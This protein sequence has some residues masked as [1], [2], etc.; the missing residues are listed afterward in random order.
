MKKRK[1][2]TVV[3]I[4]RIVMEAPPK[5]TI[6]IQGERSQE[7]RTGIKK[8]A[9]LAAANNRNTINKENQMKNDDTT[10]RNTREKIEAMSRANEPS[11][12]T[13]S[14]RHCGA[15]CLTNAVIDMLKME[16]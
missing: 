3:S 7:M 15:Y 6:P 11:Y 8:N 10:L 16:K 5:R 2:E 12:W 1:I 4:F 13:P 14:N 9:A